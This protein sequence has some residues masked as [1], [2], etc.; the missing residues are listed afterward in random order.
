MIKKWLK[1]IPRDYI[2]AGIIIYLVISFSVCFA[3]SHNNFKDMVAIND[4]LN[5]LI[6]N[7]YEVLVEKL[8][9][10][11]KDL[12]S[13]YDGVV[14]ELES[15]KQVDLPMYKYTEEE[16]YLLAQCVEAE[17]GYSVG[18][19]LNQKYITQVILNRV[20]S[21]KFP[22]TIKEVIYDKPDGVVQ[23]SVAYNGRIDREVEAETLLNVYSVL[24]YG[25]DLPEYVHYAYSEWLDE[26][27]LNS[28]NVHSIL[29][30]IVFAYSDYDKE[31]YYG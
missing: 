10:A 18:Q 16:I 14:E 17:A 3:I 2:Y 9:T 27:W 28:L 26:D 12:K 30:G 20:Q 22:N 6:D 15:M 23:F 1:K 11:Y 24:L 7:K 5:Y 13:E 4:E 21:G 31:E 29:D 8:K 19:G 25:T